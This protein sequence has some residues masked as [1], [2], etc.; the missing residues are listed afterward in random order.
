MNKGRFSQIKR[1]A[2]ATGIA[3]LALIC[4]WLAV[5]F[6]LSALDIRIFHLPLW[7]VAG[8]VG[9]WLFALVLVA[10]LLR[11]VFRDM[12][13]EDDPA[14]DASAADALSGDGGAESRREEV[15]RDA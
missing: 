8:T 1:E 3:L 15:H 12:P 5:G 9:T 4:Y 10:G 6:G 13:L 14:A 7:A 11:F 2:T